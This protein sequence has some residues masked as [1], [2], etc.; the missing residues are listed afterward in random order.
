MKTDQIELVYKS[1]SG[2]V[3]IHHYRKDLSLCLFRGTA[4]REGVNDGKR[5]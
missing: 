2:Y 4:A 5:Y 1:T 3:I